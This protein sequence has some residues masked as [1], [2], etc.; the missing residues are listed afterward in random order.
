MP[1]E[2]QIA[3]K[4]MHFSSQPKL[5]QSSL[6]FYTVTS[7]IFW[8]EK[9][10]TKGLLNSEKLLVTATLIKFSLIQ[11]IIKAKQKQNK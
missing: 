1:C 4:T 10:K 7:K 2:S 3:F 11:T 6:S 5:S 9:Q 8:G